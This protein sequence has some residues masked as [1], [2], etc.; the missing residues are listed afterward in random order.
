MVCLFRFHYQFSGH[1]WFGTGS[2]RLVSGFQSH[3]PIL[4]HKHLLIRK[5]LYRYRRCKRPSMGNRNRRHSDLVS[6]NRPCTVLPL[7][8]LIIKRVN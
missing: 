7:N 8:L 5:G 2:D 6:Y 4:Y 3:N 1:Q